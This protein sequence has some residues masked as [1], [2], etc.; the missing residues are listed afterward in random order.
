[1]PP[2]VAVAAWP[3]VRWRVDPRRRLPAAEGGRRAVPV[4][5]QQGP[6]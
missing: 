2:T 6:W 3:V 4:R 5:L 1:M